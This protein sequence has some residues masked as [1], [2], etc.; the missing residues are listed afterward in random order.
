MRTKTRRAKKYRFERTVSRAA[1]NHCVVLA[2]MK[3]S[4]KC[5]RELL[6]GLGVMAAEVGEGV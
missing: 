3:R 1:L 4:I 5:D 6:G 2:T